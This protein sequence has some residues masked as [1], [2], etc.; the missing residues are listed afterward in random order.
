M[1]VTAVNKTHSATQTWSNRP[2]AVY[3]PHAHVYH[4]ILYCVAGSIRFKT[5]KGT[6]TKVVPMK[7]GDRLELPPHT[8][9][10]AVV[11]PKGVTC[12]ETHQYAPVSEGA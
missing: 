12:I 6:V 11:G 3:A 2:G 10:S 5:H 7:A 4:K 8:L 1:G 9:H